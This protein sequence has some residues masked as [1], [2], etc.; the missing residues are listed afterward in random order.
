MLPDKQIIGQKIRK[1][2]DDFGLSLRA[3]PAPA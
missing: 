1:R 3:P 2:R